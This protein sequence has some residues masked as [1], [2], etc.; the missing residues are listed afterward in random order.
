MTRE[1]AAG[2]ATAVRPLR[3]RA[4]ST[5]FTLITNSRYGGAKGAPSRSSKSNAKFTP[6]RLG[7]RLALMTVVSILGCAGIAGASSWAVVLTNGTHPA[8]S[9]STS[10]DPPTGGTATNPNA[11]SL[12]VSWVMPSTGATPTGY[13]VTRDGSAVPGGSGC[14]AAITTIST[15]ASCT[16]S[17][18]AASTLY[19]YDVTALVGTH[20]KSV[21][22][23]TF[24]GTT[25]APFVITNITSTNAPGNTVGLM[26]VGDTFAV[27]F[28]YAVDPSTVN[29][30][31][32]ASAMTL[33]FAS[34]AIKIS[35]LTTGAGF[36]VTS[37]YVS[38]GMSVATGTLSLSNA[39]T[40]VTFT[41]TG[42]PSNPAKLVAGPASIFTFT[43]LGAIEDVLGDTASSY[44]QSP[45]LQ[46]F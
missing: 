38:S 19:T 24:S 37:P 40:T 13:K 21:A 20:W 39:N 26:G 44:S 32:D 45:A 27:T 11:S 28:N 34:S 4:L 41:V 31:A 30:V 33:V 5:I 7:R 22:S 10:V 25:I 18:L 3:L 17:G 9:Q 29:T 35:G 15:T 42:S 8:M 6:Q 36:V 23:S 12:L 14:R 16:D 46:I 1:K 43:P 2:Q